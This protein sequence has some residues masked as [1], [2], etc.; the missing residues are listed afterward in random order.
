MDA[1]NHT[2]IAN[3][4]IDKWMA[5]LNGSDIKVL[6][7][8]ARKTIG[9]HKETD[10]ISLSQLEE[11]TGSARQTIL[12]A[13]DRLGNRGLI[14][15]DRSSRINEFEINYNSLKNRPVQKLDQEESNN[16]TEDGLKTRHTKES[17]ETKQKKYVR[18]LEYSDFDKSEKIAK[19]TIYCVSSF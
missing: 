18:D 4:I 6:L 17:K 3:D 16:K 15:V 11:L 5:E 8:I 2:Q 14:N 12:D 1:P 7:A 9:W 10:Q 19:F 13:I